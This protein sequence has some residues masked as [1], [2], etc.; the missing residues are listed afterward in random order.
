MKEEEEEEWMSTNVV[1][2]LEQTD[3]VWHLENPRK[4]AYDP[5]VQPLLV[6]F[7]VDPEQRVCIEILLDAHTGGH[8]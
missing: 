5:K 4:S 2:N 6:D 3:Y 7:Y 8:I 1:A